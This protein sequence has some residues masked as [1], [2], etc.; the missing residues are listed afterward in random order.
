MPKKR[1]RTTL[2]ASMPFY[3]APRGIISLSTYAVLD[4]LGN[5]KRDR[6]P[7]L[8]IGASGNLLPT[9]GESEDFA[10]PHIEVD[11]RGYHHVVVE[12]GVERNRVTTPDLQEFLYRVFRAITSTLAGSARRVKGEDSRRQLFRRQIE[13]LAK[14]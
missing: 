10:L 1:M 13:L 6:A 9:Y 2:E 8:I 7:R 3:Q 11:S 4:T 5:Q 14:L 12:R